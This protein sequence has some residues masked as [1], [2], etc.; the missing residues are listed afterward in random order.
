[1][2]RLLVAMLLVSCRPDGGTTAAPESS[3][4]RLSEPEPTPM[5]AVEATSLFGR[6]LHAPTLPESIRVARELEL[7]QAAKHWQADPTNLE[8]I[9]WYG[10]R[11]AYLGRYREALTVFSDGLRIH[12]ES[13]RLLR[14]RGHRYITIRRFDDAVADLERAAQLML[15][16]PDALEVDGLP[17]AAGVPTG[18]LYTNV[19]Y[20]LALAHYLRGDFA[21]AAEAWDACHD[22]ATTDDMRVAATYWLAIARQRHG[23]FDEADAALARVPPDPSLHENFAYQALIQLFRG[24]R[25]VG[26]VRAAMESEVDIATIGYGLAHWYRVRNDH[27]RSREQLR[28]VLDSPQW[29]AF[30]Y[31]AAEADL[32]AIERS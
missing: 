32:F 23:D 16:E 3:H 30:G 17:N 7:E 28:R 11:L 1:M 24:D 13:A 8:A 19:W 5:P 27:N 4:R 10:R 21:R 14:H 9:A 20:H 29:A 31:I 25:S 12:P 6:S 22:S 2:K 18:T 26:D 15:A